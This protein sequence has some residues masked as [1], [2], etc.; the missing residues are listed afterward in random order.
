ME[1]QARGEVMAPDQGL[2]IQLGKT[3]KMKHVETEQA[4]YP[5]PRSEIP[6]PLGKC[7]FTFWGNLT[8]ILLP[9]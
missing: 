6:W 5:Y 1:G 7:S 8:P 3:T 4:L 2:T 9:L